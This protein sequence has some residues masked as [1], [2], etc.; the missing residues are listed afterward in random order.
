MKPV[1]LSTF[2]KTYDIR[3]LVEEQLTPQVCQ[4]LGTAFARVIAE[5][6]GHRSIVLGHDMRDSSPM[7]AQAFADGVRAA[8]LDVVSIGLCATDQ[9]YFASGTQQCPGAMITASHNPATYNG[10]KLCRSEAVPLEMASGLALV[11][12]LAQ[13]LLDR[14]DAHPLASTP[15]SGTTGAMEHR[16][17]LGGYAAY[18][19]S[20]VDLRGIRPLRVVV[21]A[22]SGMAG[23]TAPA[24]LGSGSSAAGT[25]AVEMIGLYLELDGTFPHHEANPL[26]P[27]NIVDL[28]A[29][30]LA[31]GADLGLAFDGD[32]DRCFV[33]DERGAAVTASA[34]TAL[35][36][37]REI[38]KETA[39]GVPADQVS[40][41]HNSI[42]SR[43]VP[44]TVAGLGARAVMTKV[45][46]SYV[47]ATMAEHDAVFG[48]EHSGHYYFRDFWWADTGMLAA[49]HV[50]AALGHQGVGST[51]SALAAPYHPYAHSGEINS[52]IKDAA[53]AL[54]RVREWANDTQPEPFV[55]D[56]D[57]LGISGSDADG[58][59]WT[60][61]VRAS[62]TEPLVR[63]NVEAR[64]QE[65]MRGVRDAVLAVI[66]GTVSS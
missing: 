34:I 38:E 61:S 26:D 25:A 46:H 18:L 22:G 31:H 36:A 37:A 35:V 51:M 39:R 6:D 3:G 10:I 27:A 54:D 43:A 65:T 1:D 5:P 57:G 62:N 4:A 48:G 42:T 58:G 2:I 9:L 33:V 50:L 53:S 24:V 59:F 30:V 28:Q 45:G 49:L 44:E 13:M 63:L 23:L 60:V 47:K 52:V 19:H 29:A 16:D 17:V 12:D 14:G 21:D 15:P 55:G 8:G 7:L 41:V 56:F 66:V 11:R 64:E 32:A 40:V 20:L